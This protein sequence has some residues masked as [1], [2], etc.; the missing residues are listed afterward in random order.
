MNDIK[1][2]PIWISW[3]LVKKPDNE[4]PTKVPVQ[5]NGKPA[6]STDQKTWTTFDKISGNKGIVF[7]ASAGIIGIDF[8]HC[9]SDGKITNTAVADFVKSAKTYCE[10]SPSGTGLHLLFKSS[11][12][13][14]LQVNKHYLNETESVEIYTWGRYFTFTGNEHPDSKSL[15]EVDNDIFIQLIT[16]LGYPWGKEKRVTTIVGGTSYLTSE[17]ILKKMFSAKNGD[18]MKRIYNGDTTEYNKDYSSTDFALCCSLAFWSNRDSEMMSQIWLASPLG[19]REKTQDQ[20]DAYPYSRRTIDKAIL[21][22][23]EV[24]TPPQKHEDAKYDFILGGGSDKKDPSPLLIA[25]NIH[26]ILRMSPLFKEQFRRNTFSHMVETR[27][28]SNEWESLNDSVITATREYIVE[29]FYFFVR[30]S[31]QMTQEAILFVADDIKINPPRDY[32]TSLVWDATP[33]LNSWLYNAYGVADDE[34]HQAIGSNWLKGLVK[35]VIHPGCQFDEVLA[36]ES[37]QGWRKSTS[38]RALGTPWHVE[39]THSTDNK[40]FYLLL[41]QNVIVEFSEG[42]IFDRTSVKKLKAEITKTEDQ[43]RPPYERGILKFKRACVFAVTT[44]DL[45]LKDSTGNR[46]WLPV[47]LKKPADIDWIEANRDQLYA[48]AY[49]RAIIMGESTWEYPTTLAEAQE[50][51]T[52][53][54]DYDEKVIE[55]V[56]KHTDENL[57]EEGIRLHDAI[58]STYGDG[59]HITGLEETRVAGTLRGKLKMVSKPKRLDGT[60]LRRWFPTDAT[61]EITRLTRQQQQNDF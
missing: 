58:R 52:E 26:R 7:E 42:E 56:A 12:R 35:R 21:A 9:V 10:Y 34:L 60:L 32:I 4:K 29:N 44:N 43:V 46:R 8:D 30:L 37:P 55:W 23:A 28:G 18:K 11:E 2:L 1:K 31:L 61:L 49:Y 13:I 40:D 53:W 22:T 38:I 16:Q 17:E 47:T 33:R 19:K 24:Y 36:L 27:F 59:I 41:A 54:S 39:T 14:D 20:K 3:K 45:E 25:P 51:H 48:E 6:S 57:V 50:S 15:L 5:I